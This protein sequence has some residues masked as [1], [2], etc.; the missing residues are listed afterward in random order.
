MPR[1]SVCPA[2]QDLRSKEKTLRKEKRTLG[3]QVRSLTRRLA[4]AE[5]KI[6]K[7]EDIKKQDARARH[8][9]PRSSREV[10]QGSPTECGHC[11]SQ[12]VAWSR[13]ALIT[14]MEKTKCFK[15]STPRTFVYHSYLVL[16]LHPFRH[17]S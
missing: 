7:Q 6:A 9:G 3:V 17:V 8:E 10:L 13:W 16:P 11:A 12:A 1:L 5:K 15:E 2:C 14:Q 4:T